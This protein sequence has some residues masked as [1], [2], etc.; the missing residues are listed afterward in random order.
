MQLISITSERLQAAIRRLFPSQAGFSEDLQATNV[1][2]PIIDL[3]PTAEGDDVPISLSQALTYDSTFFSDSASATTIAS[4]PGFYRI[5]GTVTLVPD[6]SSQQVA[7]IEVFDGSVYKIV[8]G[9]L[10]RSNSNS[11]MCV[12]N[13]DLLVFL[14]QGES[15]LTS[16]DNIGCQLLGTCRQVADSNGVTV[17]P[18]GFTPQ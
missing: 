5:V 16:T 15:I 12:D 18:A 17:N 1:I 6:S 13:F 10:L 4:L 7:K 8:Y 3:T 9:Y 2:Q 14:A 11:S